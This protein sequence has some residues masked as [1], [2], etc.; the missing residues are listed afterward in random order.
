MTTKS[1]GC[2]GCSNY[3]CSECKKLKA[4]V[5]GG[6]SSL[7]RVHRQSAWLSVTFA[8]FVNGKSRGQTVG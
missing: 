8:R 4:P 2:D 6:V 7:F 3:R 1:S 5:V